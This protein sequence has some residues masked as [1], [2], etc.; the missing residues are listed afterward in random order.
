M[1][2]SE[3][4]T[5]FGGKHVVFGPTGFKM[6]KIKTALKNGP[7]ISDSNKKPSNLRISYSLELTFQPCTRHLDRFQSSRLEIFDI[8]KMGIENYIVIAVIFH[9][10]S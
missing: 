4:L 6:A 2:H 5:L 10:L 3:Y 1:F 8:E 9:I 7:I